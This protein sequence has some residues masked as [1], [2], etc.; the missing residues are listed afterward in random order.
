M[1]PGGVNVFTYF[2][3]TSASIDSWKLNGVVALEKLILLYSISSELNL[4]VYIRQTDVLAVPGDPTRS[5][6]RWPG[7]F[8]L[9]CLIT[10]RLAIFYIINSVRV[11]SPVGMRS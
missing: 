6:L 11:D 8:L 7:S 3:S 1:P 10:G 4:P 2:F 5:V 9:A